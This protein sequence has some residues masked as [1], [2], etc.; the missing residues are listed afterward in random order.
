MTT[1]VVYAGTTDGYTSKNKSG[2]ADLFTGDVPALTVVQQQSGHVTADTSVSATFSPAATAGNVLICVATARNNTGMSL[3]GWTLQ[4]S[5]GTTGR[6]IYVWAKTAAGGET[7]VTVTGT[8]GSV[9]RRC[10]IYEL[11]QCAVPVAASSTNA[12]SSVS[13]VALSSTGNDAPANSAIIGGVAL[14]NTGAT[15]VP[16]FSFDNSFTEAADDYDC[17]IAAHR[18]YATAATAQTTTA[19]WTTARNASTLQVVS[20]GPAITTTTGT[21]AV[22]LRAGVYSATLAYESFMPFDTTPIGSDQVSA[23]TLNV[24]AYSLTGSPVLHVRTDDTWLGTWGEPWVWAAATAADTLLAAYDTTA[25]W[26]YDTAYDLTSEAAFPAAI[27]GAGSTYMYVT[28]TGYEGSSP[29][30]AYAYWYPADTAGTSQDPKLTVVHA[31]AA[32]GVISVGMSPI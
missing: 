1:T 23:A 25:G 8:S 14:N 31:A 13:S 20:L 10:D 16:A 22:M 26:T 7:T 17:A 6:S 9:G 21:G 29:T 18:V 11:A 32:G 28:T 3:S 15:S 19:T 2:D 5:N 4:Q 27:N 24:T 12:G 30:A